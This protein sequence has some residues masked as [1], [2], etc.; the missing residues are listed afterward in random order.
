M[1][2]YNKILGEIL[3]ELIKERKAQGITQVKLAEMTGMQAPNIAL[4]ETG[5]RI[6][7]LKTIARYADAL[8]KEINIKLGDA[9]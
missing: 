8:G 9:K 7:T 2:D 3:A 6:P 1:K 5:S 4:L